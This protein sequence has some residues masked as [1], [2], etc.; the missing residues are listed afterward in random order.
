[1]Q[2]LQIIFGEACSRENILQGKRR[3]DKKNAM[4]TD[5]SAAHCAIKMRSKEPDKKRQ[6][7]SSG[8][9][10]EM[11]HI[12]AL[13]TMRDVAPIFAYRQPRE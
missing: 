12:I 4:S 2:V 7:N 13:D 8:M 1:M 9:I 6:S 10:C 5:Y 3:T 11:V